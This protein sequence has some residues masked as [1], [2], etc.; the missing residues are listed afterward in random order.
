M[1]W[2]LRYILAAVL[3]GD[4]LLLLVTVA[5]FLILKRLRARKR[6]PETTTPREIRED[7]EAWRRIQ[8]Y[9]ASDAYGTGGGG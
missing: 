8:N 4:F 9:S 2:T 3:A 1:I 6:E 5:L 7:L